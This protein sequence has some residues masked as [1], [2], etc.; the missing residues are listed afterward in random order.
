MDNEM[1]YLNKPDEL[2]ETLQNNKL[3]LYGAGKVA[4]IVLKYC[5]SK[6]MIINNIF[7]SSKKCNPDKLSDIPVVEIGTQR[8]KTEKTIL[9]VCTMEN[10]HSEIRSEIKDYHFK[11][12]YYI[13]NSLFQ[14]IAENTADRNMG[15]KGEAQVI[16]EQI[17]LLKN[18][19]FKFIPRPCIEYM[20]VNILDHCNLRCKG[21]D[22]FACIAD[23]Y[24]VPEETIHR[25]IKRMSELFKGDN[26]VQIAVMG[27][28]PLLHP[29]LNKILK[30]VRESFPY[31]IIRL[32][33]N[34]LLLLRQN[35]E[36]WRVCRENKVTIVNTKYPINL[37]FEEM[38]RKAS[39]ENVSFK[40]FEGTGDHFVKKSFK[41]IINLEGTSNPVKSFANCHVSNYGNFLMEGKLYGCPFS[42]QS[43]RIFNKKYNQN[44]RLTDGDYL[45]IYK[46]QDMKEILEFAS[47][48]RTYCRYCSG[49]SPKFDWTR[50]RQE[51]T[52][53]I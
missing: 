49:L 53:W 13:T 46:V 15:A 27:G 12:V 45:D 21:C 44:L 26:I 40:F 42:C 31:A 36:F 47:K 24:F 28:E 37:N 20:V 35:E 10:L 6:G 19:M 34:G 48:P 32:T 7:V 17:S 1:K 11:E 43:Y 2:V 18:S 23:P 25:D 39:E 5:I 52:E 50:S 41:K 9:L 33:T 8:E 29:E 4:K 38:K 16:Q 51:I 3:A 14:W 30:D 22:H